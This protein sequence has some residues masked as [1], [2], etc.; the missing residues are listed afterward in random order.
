M[1]SF[2]DLRHS[3]HESRRRPPP[4]VPQ[5]VAGRGTLGGHLRI[6]LILPQPV[7]EHS[8]M[9]VGKVGLSHPP[10]IHHGPLF[11]GG[12]VP[13]PSY[14]G[15][16]EH[17]VIAP[18]PFAAGGPDGARK[19]SS[20]PHHSVVGGIGCLFVAHVQRA[21]AP[22]AHIAPSTRAPAK[23]GLSPAINLLLYR[24]TV[25]CRIDRVSAV[26]IVAKSSKQSSERATVFVFLYLTC[27]LR[28]EVHVIHLAGGTFITHVRPKTYSTSSR[29]FSRLVEFQ[30]AKPRLSI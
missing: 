28:D 8:R 5:G 16:S 20:S 24:G 21:R 2:A 6:G 18:E 22:R 29:R 14:N 13:S 9:I 25:K 7:R 12:Q 30:R 23:S 27:S 11:N 1:A 15:E 26:R 17:Y 19:F 10:T 3:P 4:I